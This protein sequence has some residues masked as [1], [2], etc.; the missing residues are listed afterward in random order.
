MAEEHLYIM[1]IPFKYEGKIK[2][3]K[4]SDGSSSKELT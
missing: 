4:S 2:T 3:V 1:K